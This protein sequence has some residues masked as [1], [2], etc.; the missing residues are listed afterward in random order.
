MVV[1]I[2]YSLMRCYELGRARL[3]LR[4]V[5]ARRLSLAGFD[6]FRFYGFDLTEIEI[7][8]EGVILIVE[9][10]GH[11]GVESRVLLKVSAGKLVGN[12]HED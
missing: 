9:W 7:R 4:G 11:G 3:S 2:R 12:E 8:E 10:V 5:L 1:A 6:G